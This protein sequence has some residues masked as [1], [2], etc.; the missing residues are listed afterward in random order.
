MANYKIMNSGVA[1]LLV[2]AF[3][4]LIGCDDQTVAARRSPPQTALASMENNSAVVR[5]AAPMEDEEAK[6]EHEAPPTTEEVASTLA[7][8]QATLG[9]TMKALSEILDASQRMQH[10]LLAAPERFSAPDQSEEHSEE[11]E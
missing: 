1:A 5:A 3:A 10:E 8:A 2:V 11:E 4:I 9:A 7:D 6:P